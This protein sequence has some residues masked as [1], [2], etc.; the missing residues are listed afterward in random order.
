MANWKKTID[1]SDLMDQYYNNEISIKDLTSEMV[2]RLKKLPYNDDVI[3]NDIVFE[4]DNFEPSSDYE[5]AEDEFNE[6][7]QRLY[8]WA[9]IKHRL[10][11]NTYA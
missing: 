5:E 10:W 6:I 11:I 8:D 2:I 4:L 3:F 1:I 9:D 7:L